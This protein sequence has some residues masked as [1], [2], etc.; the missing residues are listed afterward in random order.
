MDDILSL[1]E[2]Q[3]VQQLQVLLEHLF[4]LLH[5]QGQGHL[6]DQVGQALPWVL[7]HL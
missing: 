5:Q 2:V 7:S 6:V 4:F 1:L 3:W